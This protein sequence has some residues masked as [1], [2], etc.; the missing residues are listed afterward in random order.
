MLCSTPQK[1]F[2]PTPSTSTLSDII[3]GQGRISRI[4][5]LKFTS[6]LSPSI[7]MGG[8]GVKQVKIT[9]IF[10]FVRDCRSDLDIGQIRE[11]GYVS[12]PQS[13]TRRLQY[14]NGKFH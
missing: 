12:S 3:S 7:D 1:K 13:T 9:L 8:V 5:S 11:S 4:D 10:I 6:P 14:E 2:E